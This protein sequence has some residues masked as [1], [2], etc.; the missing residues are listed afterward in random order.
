MKRVETR[1]GATHSRARGGVTRSVK[2]FRGICVVVCLA[3]S[4]LL[5]VMAGDAMAQ[6]PNVCVPEEEGVGVITPVKGACKAKYTLS[7]LPKYVASGVGGKPTLV[8]EGVNVQIESGSGSTSGTV[9]GEGNLVIGYDE[10]PGTQTGSHNL[11]LGGEQTYTSYGGILAGFKDTISEPFASVTGGEENT[12]GGEYASVS[13]GRGNKASGEWA[14]ASGG[15]NN[16]AENEYTSASGDFNTAS[17]RNA[18]VSGGLDNDASGYRSSVSGGYENT[19]SG[20]YSFVCGGRKNT[21]SGLYSS[22]CGGKELKAEEEY[23]AK[24]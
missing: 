4:L 10:N 1:K 24:L 6:A 7:L 21:A 2:G 8:F 9:N 19:A 14:S 11:I 18:S 22:V 17:G 13:G 16:K 5:L 15:I 12:A 23:G 3:M 20:E